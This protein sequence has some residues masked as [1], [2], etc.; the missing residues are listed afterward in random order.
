MRARM[1]KSG[2]VGRK[3][4][5]TLCSALLNRL[6]ICILSILHVRKQERLIIT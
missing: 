5:M 6:Q 3:N 2:D 4:V 1:L